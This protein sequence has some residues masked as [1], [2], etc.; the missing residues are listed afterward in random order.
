MLESVNI[1]NRY[2]A[3][4][5]VIM[6]DIFKNSNYWYDI[7]SRKAQNDIIRFLYLLESGDCL[8]MLDWLRFNELRHDDQFYN[9]L[10]KAVIS[11]NNKI[12][13][14][15]FG[16]SSYWYDKFTGKSRSN[17][18]FFLLTLTDNESD[19]LICWCKEV[20]I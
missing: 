17:I 7:F 11:F 2:L 14:K 4:N 20:L 5:N 3:L 10:D 8:R 1:Y 9:N 6:N 19:I 15:L 12:C 18:G 16:D 13:F